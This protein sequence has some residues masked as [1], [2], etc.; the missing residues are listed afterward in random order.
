MLWKHET[1]QLLRTP[2]RTLVFCLALALVI[3]LLCVT[4]GLRFATERAVATIEDMYV[5]VAIIPRV[6]KSQYPTTGE[7]TLA[8]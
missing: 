6:V 2:F 3:G 4:M 7:Y 1:K 8:K 5:T